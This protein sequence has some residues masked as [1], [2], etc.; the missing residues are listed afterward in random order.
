MG[1]ANA[2]QDAQRAAAY[3][4]LGF[5]GTYHLALRDLPGLIREHVR[6]RRAVDFGCGTGRSTRFLKELGFHA[7]GVDIAPEMVAE[8]RRRDPG[9]DYRVVARGEVGDLADRAFDLVLS[10]FTFDNVPSGEKPGLF[11]RLRRL[12]APRGRFVNLVCTPEVYTREWA[13]FTTKAF[14]TNRDARSGDVVLVVT[15]DHPDARPVEDVLC[16]DEEYRAVFRGA[17]LTVVDV[18][19]PLARGDEPI[20][21]ASETET[22]PFALYVLA[23]VPG[24]VPGVPAGS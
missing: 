1:L 18:H 13:S 10:S 17:G 8:A 11:E 2:Y 24:P 21:W 22:P 12:L 14:P 16:T 9:G 3:A 5:P 19:R 15:T 6:G 4:R 20:R 23:P 7:V